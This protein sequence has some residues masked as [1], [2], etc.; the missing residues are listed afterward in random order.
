GEPTMLALFMGARLVRADTGEHIEDLLVV[1]LPVERS[2]ALELGEGVFAGEFERFLPL[3]TGVLL[4]VLV[5]LVG[6]VFGWSG[7][8]ECFGDDVFL[9][10]GVAES[11][12]RRLDELAGSFPEFAPD[13]RERL[14][15]RGGIETEAMHQ[16]RA[17]FHPV[18]ELIL[19][20]PASV[21]VEKRPC[22]RLGFVRDL[23]LFSG[24]NEMVGWNRDEL[25]QIP[26]M[27]YVLAELLTV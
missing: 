24:I 21:L 5:L 12:S 8:D 15:C 4:V 1:V 14:L 26:K 3:S 17:L 11:D 18:G 13:V 27:L 16:Y 23:V 20:E 25:Y 22:D 10:G 7:W 19:R 9:D 2:P 6:L